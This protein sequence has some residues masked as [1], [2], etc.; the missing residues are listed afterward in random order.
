MGS[1]ASACSPQYL[2]PHPLHA[3]TSSAEILAGSVDGCVRRF[4]ARMGRLF[5]DELHHPVTCIRGALP[6]GLL[7][8]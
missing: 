1:A 3:A 4:D 5:I 6:A 7:A 8:Y 2:P